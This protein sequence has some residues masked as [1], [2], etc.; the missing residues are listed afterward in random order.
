MA[1][2]SQQNADEDN[3]YPCCSRCSPPPAASISFSSFP[4]PGN[5]FPSAQ[6]TNP[7]S[8][9][10]FPGNSQ[11]CTLHCDQSDTCPYSPPQNGSSP[12]VVEDDCCA[13]CCPL[14]IEGAA[15]QTT[16]AAAPIEPQQQQRPTPTPPPPSEQ[17]QKLQPV[18]TSIRKRKYEE[19]DDDDDD[20]YDNEENAHA[21][22]YYSMSEQERKA[23]QWAA[24]DEKFQQ[25]DELTTH[26]CKVHL[27]SR[28]VNIHCRWGPCTV[29]VDA[30]DA[31][32]NHLSDHLG[33]RF[34]HICGWTNCNQRFETFDE[35]TG[36]LSEDHVGTGKSR[37]WC[38]WQECHRNGK[39]FTQRQK[40]MR[41]IQTHTGMS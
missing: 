30:S 22:Y 14:A 17:A 7:S 27:S 13:E 29:T 2:P 23:C 41:H 18:E 19:N 24:C 40:V 36:H 25:V 38:E 32:F 16:T 15:T 4:P 31:L 11:T 20:D 28:S 9:P 26:V 21:Y 5:T 1:T 12:A 3:N 8:F 37:Y 6:P 34:L 35:L 39:S 10:G 33:Q